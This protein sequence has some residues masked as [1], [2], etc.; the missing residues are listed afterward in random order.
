MAKTPKHRRKQ[1]KKTILM[2]NKFFKQM[3]RQPYVPSQDQLEFEKFQDEINETMVT[4]VFQPDCS[5]DYINIVC[6]VNNENCCNNF[7]L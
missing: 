6:K 4:L 2:F 3:N 5:V 7:I 1:L